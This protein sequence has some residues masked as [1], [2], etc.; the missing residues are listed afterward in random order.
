MKARL[1]KQF[2]GGGGGDMNSMLRQAQKMQEDIKIVQ[3]KINGTEFSATVGGGVFTATVTG[4]KV[5][6]SVEISPEIVNKD[7]IEDLE[8]LVV[9][10]VNA[11]MSKAEEET[12]KEMEKITGGVTFPGLV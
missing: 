5:V 7:S 9:A 6:K 1:P 4:D 12:A 11:A 2:Q 10:G 8:D 3:E